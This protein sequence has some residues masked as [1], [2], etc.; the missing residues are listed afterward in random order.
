M[1]GLASLGSTRSR[2]LQHFITPSK[3]LDRDCSLVQH[4]LQVLASLLLAL[5][6]LALADQGHVHVVCTELIYMGTMKRIVIHFGKVRTAHALSIS[7]DS[8]NAAGNVAARVYV[9]CVD[10]SIAY[11]P[12]SHNEEHVT[13]C[14][15][16]GLAIQS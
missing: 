8:L 4:A 11:S 14:A 10:D 16:M 13:S 3:V 2:I 7:C 12:E 5:R 9:M 1:L 15:S 6:T